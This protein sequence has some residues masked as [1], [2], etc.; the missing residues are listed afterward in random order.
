MQVTVSFNVARRQGSIHKKHSTNHNRSQK[1]THNFCDKSVNY[2]EQETHTDLLTYREQETY[3]DQPTVYK[4][5]KQ[6]SQNIKKQQK[7]QET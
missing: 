1:K 4:I 5:L 2:R 3:L 7:F 6:I